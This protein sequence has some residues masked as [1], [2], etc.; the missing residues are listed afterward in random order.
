MGNDKQPTT[1][2][3]RAI[4][5][6]PNLLTLANAFSGMAALVCLATEEVV[7][8][9]WFVAL[10]LIFDFADGLAARLLNAKSD[11]GLQLDSLA[12]TISFG[13]VPGFALFQL[14]S[15]TSGF[16]F[17]DI[18]RWSLM[19]WGEASLGFAVALAAVLRLARFN[20]DTQSRPHFL[21]LPVP[22]MTIVVLSFPLI[23]EQQYHL[24]F[25]QPV[26]S[27]LLPVLSDTY[28][29]DAS[30]L[31]L[32]ELILSAP[33][34]IVLGLCL[35]ALMLLPIPMISLKFEGLSWKTN[36]WRYAILIWAVICY[37]IFLIP[38]LG[39]PVDMGLV[40]YLIVPLIMAGYFIISWIYATFGTLNSHIG[41]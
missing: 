14:I 37:F 39:W 18:T 6:I 33:F 26:P 40:D 28:H 7:T 11:L 5:Q 19:Q 25:Y 9:I 32:V 21:G 4:K 2:M 13:V 22:A 23:L 29:W 20:I 15:S 38:Y 8:A 36:R 16:Y 24:N 31:L 35:A 27:Y 17:T 3:K 10:A 30:D 12:D 34:Y 41:K 1:L